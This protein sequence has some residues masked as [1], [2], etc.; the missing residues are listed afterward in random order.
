MLLCLGDL[1]EA[2]CPCVLDEEGQA[3]LFFPD[4]SIILYGKDGVALY[5]GDTPLQESEAEK[6]LKEH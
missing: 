1:I 4:H 6:W 5:P 2:N 3:R